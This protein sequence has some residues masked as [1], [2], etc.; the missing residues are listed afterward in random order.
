MAF[1]LRCSRI[2]GT[3]NLADV[4]NCHVFANYWKTRDKRGK[5]VLA[6]QKLQL[7]QYIR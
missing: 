6:P 5:L 3:I 7:R 2:N 1:G 4:I